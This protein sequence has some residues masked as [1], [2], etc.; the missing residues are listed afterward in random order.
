M[1]GIRAWS[2]RVAGPGSWLP[3]S[4]C[5]WPMCTWS[6][7]VAELGCSLHGDPV[8]GRAGYGTEGRVTIACGGPG[9]VSAAVAGVTARPGPSCY[10]PSSVA[11]STALA[12][13][14]RR[15][16]SLAC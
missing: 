16:I 12:T 5:R 10:L 14:I 11:M 9:R 7:W 4:G 8:R 2:V 3:G 15:K 13:P 6:S 1:L